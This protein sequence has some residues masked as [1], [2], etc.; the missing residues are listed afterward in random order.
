MQIAPERPVDQIYLERCA[1][2]VQ[3]WLKA[4]DEIIEK[5]YKPPL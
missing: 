1:K 2:A 5:I 3:A 4:E